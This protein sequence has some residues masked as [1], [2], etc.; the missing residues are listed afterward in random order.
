MEEACVYVKARELDDLIADSKFL[1]CLRDCGV[2][3]WG[4]WANACA[5]YHEGVEN[6]K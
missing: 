6:G 5:A 3:E 2:D 4:G 1:D